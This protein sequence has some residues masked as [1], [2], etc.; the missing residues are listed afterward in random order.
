VE[1]HL[2]TTDTYLKPDHKAAIASAARALSTRKSPPT[3]T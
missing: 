3:Q 2:H 1:A